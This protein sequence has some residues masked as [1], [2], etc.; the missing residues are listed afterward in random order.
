MDNLK[1]E[2]QTA[3]SSHFYDKTIDTMNKDT[4][5][6]VVIIGNTSSVTR[7]CFVTFREIM[8]FYK[9]KERKK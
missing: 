1:I 4:R 2:N 7:V 3:L 8:I 9:A 6:V 5:H